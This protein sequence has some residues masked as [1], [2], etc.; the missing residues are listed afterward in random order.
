MHQI[1]TQPEV[2]RITNPT[3]LEFFSDL[4]LT[5]N[6]LKTFAEGTFITATL[7]VNN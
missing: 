4:I 6:S 1:D 2:H 5:H 7:N 3:P